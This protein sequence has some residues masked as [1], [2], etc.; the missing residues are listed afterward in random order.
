M[1][2]TQA[3][4]NTQKQKSAK[5]KQ[6]FPSTNV[7]TPLAPIRPRQKKQEYE[8]LSDWSHAS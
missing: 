6:S 1:T 2:T 3:E 5:K 8:V 7:G 4:R